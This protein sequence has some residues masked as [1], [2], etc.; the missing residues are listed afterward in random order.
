MLFGLLAFIP[1]VHD[2][3]WWCYVL[4]R[5]SRELM[6]I[7]SM[8][9]HDG[10]RAELDNAM[11]CEHVFFLYCIHFV[12][13]F[14]VCRQVKFNIYCACR[15]KVWKVPHFSRE[16]RC[17]ASTKFVSYVFLLNIG[18]DVCCTVL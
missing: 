18:N 9:D 2:D 6:V 8:G 11:V 13:K 7:D 12:T 10:S 15:R 3:H 16:R 1:A 17:P 5:R 4:K 14:N